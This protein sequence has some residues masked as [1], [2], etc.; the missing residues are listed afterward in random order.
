MD[1]HRYLKNVKRF[2][3]QP[4]QPCEINS[5]AKL[6]RRQFGRCTAKL[7][8]P[9]TL[10]LT[11]SCTALLGGHFTSRSKLLPPLRSA[12]KDMMKNAI[13]RR[14]LI[15]GAMPIAGAMIAG[16]WQS[17]NAQ[18][19]I[20]PRVDVKSFG[21][22]P[23]A[24]PMQ[25]SKAFAAASGA[26]N[27]AGGG[28]LVMPA[29]TYRVGYQI[30][31]RAPELLPDIIRIESCS[32]PVVL[33][34]AGVLLKAADRLRFGS[35]HPQTGRRHDPPTLP[36]T[37]PAY[38]VDA[39]RMI[40]VRDCK[41][42]VRIEGF[43][44]DGNLGRYE[45]GGQWADTGRQ[46]LAIGIMLDRNT[47]GVTIAN[48]N[49]HHHGLD[50]IMLV[51]HGLTAS[52]PRYPITLIDVVCDSNARQ[53]LSWVGGT[54]LTAIRCRFSRTGRSRF[55]SAPGAGVDVEAEDSV[56]RNGRFVDCQFDD[57]SGVGFVADS[58]DS[59]NIRL[60]RCTFIGTTSWSVWPRKPGIVFQDCQFVGSIVNVFSDADPRRA[61]RFLSC[62]F[63]GDR[64][65]SPTGAVY[66][67]FL[68]NLGSGA[69]N[70][71]MSDCQFN[72]VDAG[73]ALAWTAGDVRYHNC[74]F[75]QQGK[76]VGRPRGIFTGTNR[77]QSAG[78]V[79]LYGSRFLGPVYVN[80]KRVG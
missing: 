28:T 17:A 6:V 10:P 14:T 56:C 7:L 32:R 11:T 13:S 15:A 1:R 8:Y 78:E 24:T 51:H 34:G 25:N 41:A 47:G 68:I 52:S 4:G 80:G 35:F 73:I 53:G 21:A 75:R 69:A 20:L 3:L 12:T 50:G 9:S 65:L 67:E 38:R 54:E 72:A 60:E 61:T 36:F 63:T 48:V 5:Y 55:S 76:T 44:L 19:Q 79:D 46:A 49:S 74:N 58:G 66:G 71:L 26:I 59:A 42:P 64:K 31:G 40:L 29:G 70:V 23:A 45:L 39:Y 27:R 77:I 37:D 57:N 33:E 22:S 62:R 2:T 18:P 43:E 30:R 16:R